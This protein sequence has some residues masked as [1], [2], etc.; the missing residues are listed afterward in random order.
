M[1]INK[2]GDLYIAVTGTMQDFLLDTRSRHSTAKTK[3]GF[4]KLLRIGTC[5]KAKNES[6]KNYEYIDNLDHKV[7]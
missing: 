6:Y 4:G 3:L 5:F 1:P 7:E 2:E